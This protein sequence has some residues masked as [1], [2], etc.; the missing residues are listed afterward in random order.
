MPRKSPTV[1]VSVTDLVDHPGAT[2]ELRRAIERGELTDVDTWGPADEALVSPIDVDLQLDSVI[3]GIL[4]R[5]QVSFDVQVPC[6]RCTEPVRQ[7][8]T[9]EVAE[10]FID[11]AHADPEDEW[12]EGYELLERGTAV[13]L[14]AMLRDLVV[15]D[16]PLRAVHDEPCEA[17]KVEGVEL[18]TEDD[19]RALRESIPDARWAALGDLDLS[20]NN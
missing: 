9:E 20:T 5:G 7:R 19:D 18:R 13:D 10:L 14:S 3:E 15:L 11:P 6:A 12:D 8:V 2:R 17:A 4:V 16:L 1:R